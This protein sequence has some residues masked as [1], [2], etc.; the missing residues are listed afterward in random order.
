MTCRILAAVAVAATMV[1]GCLSKGTY[2]K[3]LVEL[4]ES[5]MARAKTSEA[6]ERYQ[7]K[8]TAEIEALQKTIQSTE[9]A[10]QRRA[11]SHR[12]RRSGQSELVSGWICGEQT[13]G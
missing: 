12:K 13:G 11:L 2:T 6:F 9:Q 8:A 5:R 3:I 10:L 1:T 7:E 4:E